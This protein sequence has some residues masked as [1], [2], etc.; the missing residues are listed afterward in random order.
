MGRARRWM[1]HRALS[2]IDATPAQ[3]RVVVGEIEKLQDCVHSVPHRLKDVR[4]DLAAA[5][6]GSVLDDAALGAV[7]GRVDAATA[8]VRAVAI[9]ALRT[10]HGVLDDKQRLQV[11]EMI[12]DAGSG[13]PTGGGWRTG[14]YR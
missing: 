2:W 3:E 4:A 12:E 7:L 10:V 5:V 9:E 1:L 8:E 14:P 11:A 13:R 6:R